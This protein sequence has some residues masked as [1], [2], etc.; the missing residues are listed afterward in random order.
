MMSISPIKSV[1]KYAIILLF[2]LP[3]CFFSLLIVYNT[4]P[5]FSFNQ[6][7]I[8]ITERA[9]LFLKPLYKFSFYTHIFAGMFCILSVL[10]QFSS[11]ILKKRK[12]IH[13][14][15]GRIYVFVV[16]A[17]AAPTGLYMSFFAKGGV[18]EK[19][20]FM[21]MAISW[22]YFTANGLITA[23]QKN[24]KQHK[25]WMIR[26]YAMSLTA[27]TFRVYYIILYLFDVELTK[28]YEVSLWM[29]VI[30]NIVIAEAVIFYQSKTN[31]KPINQIV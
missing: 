4:I 30:G 28:N 5:Y 14:W 13:V 24:I 2:W 12:A 10:L 1:K 27:V 11:T 3:V 31:F 29:S 16:L 7:F 15:S 25:I 8:F 9:V 22:F 23:L 20:L 18:S 26:S 19:C 21:F 6:N 17:I